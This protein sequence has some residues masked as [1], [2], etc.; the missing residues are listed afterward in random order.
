MNPSSLRFPGE[1]VADFDALQRQVERLFG[2]RGASVAPIRSN[3]RGS[4]PQ[5]NIG[6]TP[7]AVEVFAFAP[8]V[9]AETLD[10]SIDKGL[11]TIAGERRNTVGASDEPATAGK[12]A[13]VNTVHTRE[14][15]SGSFRRVIALPEDADASRVTASYRSGVLKVRIEKRE[16][17]RPRRIQVA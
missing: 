1:S 8:G 7:E 3:A 6:S 2:L 17:S 10:L 5:V 13:A 14:R 12:P 15:S 16:S 9:D 4:F 11:L